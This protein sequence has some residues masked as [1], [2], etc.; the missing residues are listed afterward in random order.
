MSWPVPTFL[1]LQFYAVWHVGSQSLDQS[2]N[3][4]PLQWSIV[5]PT[6]LPGKSLPSLYPFIWTPFPCRPPS[7]LF[8]EPARQQLCDERPPTHHPP[9]NQAALPGRLGGLRILL[10]LLGECRLCVALQLSRRWLWW[11]VQWQGRVFSERALTSW[12]K[13]PIVSCGG[14][15]AFLCGWSQRLLGW[16][17]CLERNGPKA[18]L[19]RA[20]GCREEEPNRPFCASC[21]V[22]ARLQR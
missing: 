21:S 15:W 17:C 10:S 16:G 22:S 1:L 20:P 18:A 2:L 8:T 5:L 14:A 12:L 13:G 19:A 4:C 6:G 9:R 11:Q 3:P 7:R